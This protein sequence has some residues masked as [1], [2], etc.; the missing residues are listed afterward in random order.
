[1]GVVILCHIIAS[2][3]EMLGGAPAD[4]WQWGLY[5]KLTQRHKVENSE[6]ITRLG[7]SGIR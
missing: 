6:S 2:R 5:T 4:N 1:M 3:I 7:S